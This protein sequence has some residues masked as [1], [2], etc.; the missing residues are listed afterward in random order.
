MT[1]DKPE[2]VTK[3]CP[4]C[5]GTLIERVNKKNGSHFLGCSNWPVRRNPTTGE[6]EGCEHTENMPVDYL[7]VMLAQGASVLPGF[8]GFA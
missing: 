4:E 1:S 7:K 2:P 5:D 6:L 3:P 8:E